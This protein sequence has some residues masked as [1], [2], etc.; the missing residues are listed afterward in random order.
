MQ[1]RVGFTLVE[2]L[3]VVSIIG[4]LLALLLPAVMSAREAGRKI[5]CANNLRQTGLALQNFEST[6]RRL[7]SG[8]R[9][10]TTFGVSWWVAILP[11]MEQANLASRF[12]TESPHAGSAFFHPANGSLVDGVLIPSW[13]CPSSPLPPSRKVGQFELQMPSY[14]GIAGASS[15]GGFPETRVTA[16]CV[17]VANGEISAGGALPSNLAISFAGVTDGLSNTM[18]VAETS[19]Y[20]YAASGARYRV[21]GGNPNGW[22]TGTATM[23]TPPNYHPTSTFPPPTW[24]TVTVRYQPNMRD[25]DAAGVDDNRGANNPLL[26]AHPGGVHAVLLDGSVH[27]LADSTSIDVMKRLATRDDG[28]PLT[29][30]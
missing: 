2:L 21:D 10:G 24:N 3:V 22:I 5:T 30:P 29:L 1:R 27:F 15:D 12:D 26:S 16:C 14:V 4:L 6:H 18:V 11:F 25:Y 9:G 23:G 17:P 13:N 8:A 20:M 28:Q 7:P 19:D